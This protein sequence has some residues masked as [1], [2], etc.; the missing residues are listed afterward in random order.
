MS[1]TVSAEMW[2]KKRTEKVKYAPLAGGQSGRRKKLFCRWM[3]ARYSLS[4]FLF[5]GFFMLYSLRVNLSVAIVAM[6]NGTAVIGN[7]S[8]STDCP[9][10]D[11]SVYNVTTDKENIGEFDWDENVQGVVLGSFFYGYV[12]TQIPGG[13]LAELL[14]AKW[15]LG[16]GIL[17]TSILTLL[18]PLAARWSPIALVTLR[19]LEGFSEA[20]WVVSGLCCGRCSCMNGPKCTLGYAGKS[21]TTFKGIGDAPTI[22]RRHTMFPGSVYSHPAASGRWGSPCSVETGASTSCSSIYPTTSEAFFTTRL[23]V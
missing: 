21:C 17:I 1:V 19:I 4:I 18:T 11:G 3:P 23:A 5:C 14:G 15:L 22:Q 16:G 8:S 9:A 7:T 13:R 10:L 2:E 6:V 20:P 12:L